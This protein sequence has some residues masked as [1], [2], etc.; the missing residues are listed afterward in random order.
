MVPKEQKRKTLST[1]EQIAYTLCKCSVLLVK[2][3]HHMHKCHTNY[4]LK[5]SLLTKGIICAFTASLW[6]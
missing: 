1:Y 4:H 6:S 5:K 3:T 2:Y